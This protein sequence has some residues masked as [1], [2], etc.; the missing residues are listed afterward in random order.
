MDKARFVVKMS[1]DTFF[2]IFALVPPLP[3]LTHKVATHL[4]KYSRSQTEEDARFQT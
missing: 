2:N 1:T 3:P 4:G